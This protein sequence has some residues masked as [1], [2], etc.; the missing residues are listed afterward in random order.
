MGYSGSIFLVWVINDKSRTVLCVLL[1]YT[2]K[3]EEIFCGIEVF[4]IDKY[5]DS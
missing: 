1:Y 2:W 4:T 5:I 3:L